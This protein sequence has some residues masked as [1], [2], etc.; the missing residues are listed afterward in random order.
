MIPVMKKRDI[1]IYIYIYIYIFMNR[2]LFYIFKASIGSNECRP[3]A[4]LG[5][6]LH[7]ICLVCFISAE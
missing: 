4:K 2:H 5:N 1:Y 3:M 6:G 7:K